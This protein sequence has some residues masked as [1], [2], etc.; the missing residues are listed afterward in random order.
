MCRREY[1]VGYHFDVNKGQSVDAEFNFKIFQ[2]QMVLLDENVQN[3]L[4]GNQDK[5][6][7]CYQWHQLY[8]VKPD[9]EFKCVITL[10]KWVAADN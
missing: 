2:C 9:N 7:Q 4:V 5:S 10:T 6:Y 8:D 3:A 1:Y